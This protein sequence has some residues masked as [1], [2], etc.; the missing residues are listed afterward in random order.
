MS[1]AARLFHAITF[2][3]EAT[4][5][6][7]VRR[8][9]M[10]AADSRFLERFGEPLNFE[11]KT[12][13]DVGC[14]AGRLCIAAARMGA[15]H[16]VGADIRIEQAPGYLAKHGQDVLDKVEFLQTA[17]DLTE[18]EGREFDVVVSKDS[19]EHYSD[20]ELMVH[21]LGALTRPGGEILI[22]FGPLWKSPTGGHIGYMT[23]VPWAHLIF[24][25]AV[26]MGERRR[27]RPDED[28]EH[29]SEVAGGLNQ[30][31][32]ARFRSILASSEL[33]CRYIAANV[34][35]NPYMR[36]MRALSKVPGLQEY[37]T[38]NVYAILQ[39]PA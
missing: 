12:V 33:R 5:S 37:F 9:Y 20:P 29:W 21:K 11:D 27:F 7:G 10:T 18:L 38:H 4:D 15:Q 30:M 2:K 8:E 39:K 16:V 28:A 13:L 35:E 36:P 24:P 22:G 26:I 3:Q 14:G 17:G 19:F 6:E 1:V 25:E 32:Y 34:S 23:R 31:T